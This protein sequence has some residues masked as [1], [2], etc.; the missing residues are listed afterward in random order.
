M[1]VDDQTPVNGAERKLSCKIACFRSFPIA[2][3]E[4]ARNEHSSHWSGARCA[5]FDNTESRLT[6]YERDV[7]SQHGLGQP[8]QAQRS[9]FLESQCLLDRDGDPLRNEDLSVLSLGAKP[10]GEIA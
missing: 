2:V 8:F 6:T 3:I 5:A 7:V 10:R 9:D 4:G 1:I